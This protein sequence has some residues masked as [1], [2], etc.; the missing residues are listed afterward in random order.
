MRAGSGNARNPIYWFS[1]AE[2]QRWSVELKPHP[3]AGGAGGGGPRAIQAARPA[4][5]LERAGQSPLALARRGHVEPGA[6][7]GRVEQRAPE[8]GALSARVVAGVASASAMLSWQI[9]VARGSTGAVSD[10][11]T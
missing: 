4:E 9:Q 2:R 8:R 10:P 1:S 11:V 6:V 7:V 5:R 3:V